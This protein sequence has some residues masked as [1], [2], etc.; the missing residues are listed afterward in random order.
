MPRALVSTLLV[1]VCSVAI[2]FAQAG[3]GSITGSVTDQAGSTVPG[4]TVKVTDPATGFQQTTTTGS[5]GDYNVPSLSVGTYNVSFEKAGFAT[6]ERTGISVNV[7]V[8]S[9]VD[10]ALQVGQVQQKIE[11]SGNAS[12]VVSER[13]DLGTTL[14]SQQIL[15]LP[16]SLNGGLRDNLNFTILSPNTVLSAGNDNS[17]RI[18]GGLGMGASM[19][20]D[21]ADTMSE[22]RNDSSFQAV[23]TD[24]IS[25]F[26][27]ISNAFSAEYG[28]FSNGVIDFTTKS[29]TNQPHGSLFEYFRNTDLNARG[30]F[31]PTRSV[32]RQNNFGGTVGG[33]VVLPK[34]YDGRNKAFFFFSYEKAIYRAGNPSSLTSIPSLAMRN[35]DFTNYTDSSGKPI[36][37][38]DP[39]TTQVV[40]GALARTPF[41]GN[42]IPMNRISPVAT[43]LN[44]YLPAPNLPGSFNNIYQAGNGGNNQDVWS[45]KGDYNIT[46]NS[47]ISGL[48][49]RQFFGSPDQI[50]PIPGPL[51]HNFNSSGVNKFYRLSHDQVIT[52]T[53]LNHATF[54]WNTRSVIEYFPQRYDS[55][56]AADRAILQLPGA[57]NTSPTSN[58]LSPPEYNI[59]DQ[60]GYY[61]FWINTDS[62]SRTANV[63]DSLSW[64][65]NNHNLKFGF[66]FLRA[67]YQRIDCNTCTGQVNFSDNTTGLPGAS[68]TTGASYASFLLGQ[69]SGGNYNTSGNFSFGESYYAF[70]V[71]D[72]WKVNSKLTV[73]MGLRY[74]IPYSKT[75]TQSRVSN[76]C[77]TCPNPA[78]GGIP[79]ALQF[80][81][82][83][84]GRTGQSS[85]LDTRYNAWGPRLGVA[86]QAAHNFVV[87]AG[88]GI[89]YVPER[90]G[91]NADNALTGFKGAVNLTS[92]DSGYTPAYAL[93][94]TFPGAGPLP[95]LDPGQQLFGTVPFAARYAGLAP[96]MYS[97]NFTVEKGI[98][99][100]TVLRASYSGSAG[101]SLLA[102]RELL[103]Q[104]NP[105]YFALG[106]TL[107]LPVSSAAAQAVGV[108]KPWAAF[109]NNQSVAQA[110]RPFPQY[111]AFQ[112]SVDSDTT[113]HSTYHSF[114]FTAEHRYNNGI[115]FQMAY[116]WSKLIA[117]VEGENPSNG[118]NVAFSQ[119]TGT[120]NA[121]N[122]AADK[123][124]S[125]ED[126]PQHL[127]LSYSYDLPFGKG[128]RYLSHS[129]ALANA[130]AGGWKI[131]AIQQYQSG[132]P[133]A[134][135]SNLNTGLSSGTERANIVSGVPLINPAYNGDPSVPYINPAAF[136][137]PL[138]FTFGNSPHEITQLRAPSLL[139]EDVTLAKDFPFLR[140]GT[141]LQFAASA[142]NIGNRT[143]FAGIDTTV[144][145][146][147]FGKISSQFNSARQVQFSLRLTF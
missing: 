100:N 54:G 85:F 48:F 32:V 83:G 16:L 80:A 102:Q 55:I 87:R 116:T 51:G 126:V 88:G 19:L 10:I 124:V 53:L 127:V 114:S 49:S 125:E 68:V 145:D 111:N 26:R 133:L 92:P 120:Q 70:Y 21:G 91:G 131:T 14:D 129:N 93:G 113:G 27:L 43:T 84:A 105:A 82:N 141:A 40:G 136:T 121:Y 29:G 147:N 67:D 3:R 134:V 64:A 144:E 39:N 94:S 97:W 143:Q 137:R 31:P 108:Q 107:F 11:V 1:L 90:E 109:P 128:R 110:L 52:P 81:G 25:Q 122:R 2:C 96:T 99:Q 117:N 73:N 34:V 75:E 46:S 146:G 138:P 89:F 37:I 74:E 35:G 103:N 72:D 101:V 41:A 79:G 66:E 123:A 22:R 63:N 98:G 62:P 50:G 20:L 61:G 130:V 28:R 17:L 115:W 69:S 24:A 78:A 23:G 36:T 139:N 86:Y 58:I 15:A 13:T 18:G 38:Y 65:K 45:I 106:N 140:E 33:P 57:F 7:A 5:H 112:H 56:P 71:Q 42:K 44:K 135:T 104:V 47:R 4:A 132:F 9:R 119:D 30:F 76:L 118:G 95:N 60:Y 142:F 6:Q 77:L 8:T 59:G 12:P